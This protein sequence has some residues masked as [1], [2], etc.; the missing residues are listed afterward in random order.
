[1][2]IENFYITSISGSIFIKVIV[3]YPIKHHWYHD[4]IGNLLMLLISNILFAMPT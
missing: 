3:M 1:M 4:N 2:A